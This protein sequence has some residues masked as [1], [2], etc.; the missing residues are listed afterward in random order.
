MPSM[1]EVH[2]VDARGEATVEVAAGERHGLARVEPEGKR[3]FCLDDGTPLFLKG[4]CACRHGRRGT[5]DYD[6]WLAA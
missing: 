1:K 6:D 5:Y 2:R 3:Y 4:L